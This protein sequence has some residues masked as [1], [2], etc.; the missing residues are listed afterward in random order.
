MTES[1]EPLAV[2]VDI[3]AAVGVYE[4][5][6]DG[7]PGFLPNVEQD[8]ETDEK[9]AKDI[10][11]GRITSRGS[12][13][14]SVMATYRAT[15]GKT[16]KSMKFG[17][18]IE[19]GALKVLADREPIAQFIT[20]GIAEDMF[21]SWFRVVYSTGDV[22]GIPDKELEQKFQLAMEA[23]DA[24]TACSEACGY[25]R[26]DGWAIVA[27]M[28]DPDEQLG[29]VAE[30]FEVINI[31]IV[32]GDKGKP[33][34]Y[35]VYR[36]VGERAKDRML[37]GTVPA[38]AVIHIITRPGVT[39]WAGKSELESIYDYLTILR[40]INYG[41]GQTMFRYGSGFPDFKIIGQNVDA[42]YIKKVSEQYADVSGRTAF[43]HDEGIE[44]EF[45][46][47]G[48]ST[49][50]PSDYHDP[51]VR[52]I[53][54]AK[55]VPE[56]IL[57][58]NPSG[59]IS[60]G[61]INER[62]YFALIE[63]EQMKWTKFIVKF[64]KYIAEAIKHPWSTQPVKP[65]W[66]TEFTMSELD[67]Q[68]IAGSRT[69]QISQFVSTY[70]SRREGRLEAGYAEIPAPEHQDKPEDDMYY[71][72][73]RSQSVSMVEF[74][75]K[76]QRPQAE[77]GQE[78]SQ[79][80]QTVQGK[81]ITKKSA[82]SR[83]NQHIHGE[84]H[85]DTRLLEISM[86]KKE[87]ADVAK[88][89]TTQSAKDRVAKLNFLLNHSERVNLGAKKELAKAR[90]FATDSLE[91][92]MVE[93]V[94]ENFEKLTDFERRVDPDEG[95]LL[96]FPNRVFAKEI[97]QRYDGEDKNMY[98]SAD[99][100]KQMV[101]NMKKFPPAISWEHPPSDTLTSLKQIMG[102]VKNPRFKDGRAIADLVY[103]RNSLG[104]DKYQELLTGKKPDLSIGFF[105][106]ED[107][108]EGEFKGSAYQS[109]QKNIFVNHVATTSQGRCST[110]EGCGLR[111][112]YDSKG[113]KKF[114]YDTMVLSTDTTLIIDP[115]A[116]QGEI[117]SG[118]A[119]QAL[120]TFGNKDECVGWLMGT[121]FSRE[122]S[123]ER[124]DEKFGVVSI[125]AVKL[126]GESFED[127]DAEIEAMEKRWRDAK[128]PE[129]ELA[130][131][132]AIMKEASGSVG[133]M[134]KPRMDELKAQLKK[135][136]KDDL[137]KRAIKRKIWR[138]QTKIKQQELY[139]Q[140]LREVGTLEETLKESRRLQEMNREMQD[141]E[142]DLNAQ[143]ATKEN[144]VSEIMSEIGGEDKSQEQKLAIAFSKCRDIY[145][146]KAFKRVQDA[147]K[148]I[149]V[150]EII[151]REK[152]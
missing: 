51:I 14:A 119:S 144:C 62:G 98:K 151:E 43:F 105:Y 1:T 39:K 113:V 18:Q 136:A 40:N 17:Q 74:G 140:K 30:A 33:K 139:V 107:P 50:N 142:I 56:A 67:K 78:P 110:E 35:I 48:G 58:G 134:I 137:I 120:E 47:M 38:K 42:D 93:T 150:L 23:V 61:D 12:K 5:S 72:A 122:D 20:W 9:T 6:Y 106:D 132:E 95:E 75:D 146:E 125:D 131:L 41:M 49:L 126:V 148:I 111:V 44:L 24:R 133:S 86:L 145:G 84:Q 81:E 15:A 34:E 54:S 101:R 28:D 7:A 114:A 152:L 127:L 52:H 94:V 29:F 68:V 80:E 89:A 69:D 102:Q 103:S 71:A 117:G 88:Y 143:D 8:S 60:T 65:Q 149:D 2:F 31:E 130:A 63:S 138:L 99:E 100:I 27:F 53:C 46:G 76:P 4:P 121:G 92:R 141:L 73:A 55:K 25:A 115:K 135:D 108:T 123:Q 32:W 104:E 77:T 124:C 37:V 70:G 128:T 79:I 87:V 129:E 147:L 118:G 13:H 64:L 11:T 59:P 22:E 109:Q 19:L 10:V 91:G 66:M 16:T 36:M 26:R 82:P 3:D 45:K 112:R 97:V 85:L 21:K 83:A 57:M 90:Q 116:E 96:I